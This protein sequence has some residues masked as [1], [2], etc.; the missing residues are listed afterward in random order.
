MI[1]CFRLLDCDPPV[2]A[3]AAAC[4]LCGGLIGP[5]PCIAPDRSA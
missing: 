3:L 5:A 1:V 2:L 4:L